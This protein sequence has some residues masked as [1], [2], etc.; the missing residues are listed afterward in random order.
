MRVRIDLPAGPAENMER[1]LALLV[2]QLPAARI[3]RWSGPCVTIGAGNE[4]EAPA[5]EKRAGAA[6]IPFARRPTGGG[7]IYHTTEE[8]AYAVAV[9]AQDARI[10]RSI[11][12]SYEFVG[13]PV[14][15][16]LVDA[17]L[18]AAWSV[19]GPRPD[20]GPCCC[21]LRPDGIT[22]H[23]AGRALSGASQRRT[24]S[25]ILQHGTV[26]LGTDLPATARILG[27]DLALLESGITGLRALGVD[28]SLDQLA[29]NL[30]GEF[31]AEGA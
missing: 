4:P 1:D 15:R 24:K 22:L 8:I 23:V 17:G 21:Y 5:I 13:T 12:S 19:P 3:Y 7:P 29:A 31:E 30:A 2:G 9:P 27:D 6:R 11:R 18:D 10:P 20:G 16:L 26:L 25:A 14:R 28:R